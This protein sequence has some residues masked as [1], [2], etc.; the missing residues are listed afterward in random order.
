MKIV[1]WN[2]GEDERNENGKLNINSYNYIVDFIKKE[3]IDV[4]CLQ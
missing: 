1:T 2:I 3:N 4:I